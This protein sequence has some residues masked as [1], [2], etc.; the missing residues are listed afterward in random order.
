V[1]ESPAPSTI[2]ASDANPSPP[3]ETFDR[4]ID[5][6]DPL[7]SRLG[8][9]KAVLKQWKMLGPLTPLEANSAGVA[10]NNTFF[11]IAALHNGL[12]ALRVQ[13]NLNLIRK[14]NLP[15]I[16]E[17]PP[18]DGGPPR[19]M[20]VVGL[21]GDQFQLSDGKATF[22][23]AAASLAG[24]WNGVAHVFWK[25]FFNYKGVIPTTST[26]EAIISLKIHLKALGFSIPEMT[27]AYDTD[28]RMAVEEIQARHGLDADGKVGPLTKIVLYNEDKSLTIPRLVAVSR[29]G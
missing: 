2:A 27:A 16:L 15:A 26:G 28:T 10:D 14:L 7:N 5:S 22:T 3:A 18:A 6:A 4:A 21:A 19:F 13:G 11:R 20:A 17:F 24:L 29:G 25:N 9:L 1:A 8:A 12:E 23:V